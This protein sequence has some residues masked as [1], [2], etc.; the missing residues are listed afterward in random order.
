MPNLNSL[1]VFQ[2][3]YKTKRVCIIPIISRNVSFIFVFIRNLHKILGNSRIT[4]KPANSASD[5]NPSIKSEVQRS[6]FIV[7]HN[8]F[9]NLSDHLTKIVRQEFSDSQA[10]RGCSCGRTKTAALINCIGD[11]VFNDLKSSMQLQTFSIMLDASN[12]T[13]I[14]KCTQSL[15]VFM[16]SISTGL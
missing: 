7:Q 5:I 15:F 10:G 1:Y 13:G 3:V 4:F 12:D 11:H 6:M 9:F 8:T 2:V 14:E 16:M